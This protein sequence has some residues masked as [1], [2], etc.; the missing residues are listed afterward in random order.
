MEAPYCPLGR[1][2]PPEGPSRPRYPPTVAFST[3]ILPLDRAPEGHRAVGPARAVAEALG[4]SVRAVHVLPA[5][6]GPRAPIVA[7]ELQSALDDVE[8]AATVDI[9]VGEDQALEIA[10]LAAT[11][12]DSLV[13]MATSSGG[14]ARAAMRGS[15]AEAV[16]HLMSG[17][18]MLVGPEAG[19]AT[20][21]RGRPVVIPVDGEE[22]EPAT[23]ALA[24]AWCESLAATPVVVGVVH[25]DGH[26]EALD[27]ASLVRV[28]TRFGPGVTYELLTG[29]E[30]AD[31]VAE[32]ATRHGAG[33]I[34]LATH[35]RAG[36][37]RLVGGS[38]A[39]AIAHGAPCPVVVHQPVHVL[40]HLEEGAIP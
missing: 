19:E 2:S 15:T 7:A 24:R 11:S 17:P 22:P 33:S 29:P 23:V 21:I 4:A 38:A 16:V 32:A 30:V 34:V 3:V 35:A 28:A 39:F 10:R 9:L 12:A 18:V 25:A 40:F 20:E 31:A 27:E 6:I 5:V 1:R 13:V 36:F 14:R 26:D 8:L 37:Q